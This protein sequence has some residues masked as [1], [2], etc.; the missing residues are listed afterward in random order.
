M[1][2]PKITLVGAGGMSFGPAMVNDIVHTSRLAGARLVLH[3]VNAERLQRAFQFACK[4]NA[5]AGSPIVVEY[6]TDPEVA[7][8]GANFVISSAEFRRFE[9]WR[10]DYEIPNKYGATQIT[11]E[12]GGP[13]AVFH[14]L[15]SIHNTLGIC[16][17]IEEYCP[18]A[19]L[20]NLSNPMS[21]VTLA[22]N[23]G[24]T[25]RN[26]GMC[27]EMPGG[28][29]RLSRRLRVSAKDVEAKASGI[30]HFTFFTE[31]RNR[32]TGEDLLPRI[33]AFF[34]KG[35]FDY[36]DRTKKLL[37]RL[38]SGTVGGSLV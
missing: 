30:N 27:H 18:D 1:S 23:R 15:R 33:R 26:V 14:S 28:V 7:L 21:R 3:D 6:S 11:G 13:G 34:D 8:G 19:F 10:Q 25:V 20:L 17:S 29:H 22:I 35:F 31:F 37:Q 12:N 5:A 38:G 2:A 24:T 32:R 36:S 16:R 4:L 9:S